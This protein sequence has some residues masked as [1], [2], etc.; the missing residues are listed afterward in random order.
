MK[1]ENQFVAGKRSSTLSAT[2]SNI[3]TFDSG[4]LSETGADIILL[5]SLMTRRIHWTHFIG[6]GDAMTKSIPVI[7]LAALSELNNEELFNEGAAVCLE[8]SDKLF[9]KDSAALVHTVAQVVGNAK[10]SSK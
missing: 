1:S 10:A 9:E 4:R 3:Q 8:K 2:V 6:K 7:V 5:K